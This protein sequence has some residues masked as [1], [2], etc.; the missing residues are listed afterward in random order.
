MAAFAALY[1]HGI[2]L[3]CS[4]LVIAILGHKRRRTLVAQAL[5]VAAGA[6]ER[7]SLV[8]ECLATGMV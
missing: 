3:S 2:L 7:G 4:I 6:E 8:A 1:L 5:G